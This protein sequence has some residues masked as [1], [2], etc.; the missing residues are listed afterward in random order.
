MFSHHLIHCTTKAAFLKIDCR[1]C[2]IPQMNVYNIYNSHSSW[3]NWIW[4]KKMASPLHR[5]LKKLLRTKYLTFSKKF[6]NDLPRNFFMLKRTSSQ[7]SQ[8]M[9]ST[10]IAEQLSTMYRIG[11]GR[12]QKKITLNFVITL[13]YGLWFKDSKY[14]FLKSKK[15]GHRI[16]Q[17][18]STADPASMGWICCAA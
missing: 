5:I 8:F 4:N 18:G 3:K 1:R 7:D 14:T 11:L 17:L 13:G 16:Y 12:V 10:T 9:A 2:L 15:M 6:K